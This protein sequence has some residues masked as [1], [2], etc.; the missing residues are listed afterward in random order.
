V[1]LA[2]YEHPGGV[3]TSA[4]NRVVYDVQRGLAHAG[5][6]S[7]AGA[8]LRWELAEED[9]KHPPPLLSAAVELAPSARWLLRC[10]RV[11]FPPGAVAARHTH[12]GPGI[13]FLLH[14]S[15][16]IESGG[17]ELDYHAGEAWFEGADDPVLAT[18]SPSDETAFVRVMLLPQEWAGRRTIRYL[19]PADQDRPKLQRAAILLEQPIE[20]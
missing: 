20:P 1:L 2:L 16:R 9:E 13:R 18:A 6:A 8:A 5:A 7:I 15:I 10:D 19:D 17:V 11:D 3:E 14:G 12:P 4:G